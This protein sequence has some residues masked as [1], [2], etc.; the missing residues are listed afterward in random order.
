MPSTKLTKT[1]RFIQAGVSV[2]LYVPTMVDY[3][4]PL[5]TEL[6]AG[7]QLQGEFADLSGWSTTSNNVETPDWDSTFTPKVA[8]LVT[9]DDSS[10]TLYGS[11][12]AVDSRTLLPRGTVGFIVFMDGGDVATTGKMDVYP[13]T[14]SASPKQRSQGDTLK[15]MHNF[16]ITQEPAEDVT[17]PT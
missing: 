4:S 15:I 8:G 17:I 9:A 6:D 12:D 1:K 5:R 14:V 3:N 13:V 2:I 10:L 16:A 7:T 11:K